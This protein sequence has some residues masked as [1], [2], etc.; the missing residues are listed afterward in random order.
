MGLIGK[1]ALIGIVSVAVLIAVIW[2]IQNEKPQ[3]KDT[4]TSA[5][6]IEKNLPENITTQDTPS[7]ETPQDQT[8]AAIEQPQ[9]PPRQ[10]V[11]EVGPGMPEP[12]REQPQIPV[13][14]PGPQVPQPSGMG[15]KYVIQKDDNLHK[16]A[17]RFYGN[18]K[19]WR[20]IHTANADVIPDPEV[21]KVGAEIV[22][23][24]REEVLREKPAPAPPA[25]E[26]YIVQKGDTLSSISRMH[27]GGDSSRAQLIYQA[28]RD[29]IANKNVLKP[30]TVIT[31]PP[32]PQKSE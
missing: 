22:I 8:P 20:A 11:E 31:I 9:E 15:E 4:T 1:I 28:N 14:E 23:P 19:L 26:T 5:E 12:P 7:P 29:K 30:G 25:V 16:I 21:L 13:E 18:S 6:E 32:L 10:P 2:D 17:R 3:P 24:P 27:Y